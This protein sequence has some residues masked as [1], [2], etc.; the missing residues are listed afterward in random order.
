MLWRTWGGLGCCG[1][2]G[3]AEESFDRPELDWECCGVAGV[4]WGG[5]Y[6]TSDGYGKNGVDRCMGVALGL[7]LF[8]ENPG[9][10]RR[11]LVDLEW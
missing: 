1:V 6:L 4:S 3:R 10:P 2:R 7:N 9:W 8:F 5:F 11:V